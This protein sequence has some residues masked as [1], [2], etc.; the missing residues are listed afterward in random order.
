MSRSSRLESENKRLSMEV[1]EMKD[2]C[3]RSSTL[4]VKYKMQLEEEKNVKEDLMEGNA[5]LKKK[6]NDLS[7]RCFQQNEQIRVLES[8]LRRCS[9]ASSRASRV[10]VKVIGNISEIIKNVD[11]TETQPYIDL[12]RKYDELESEHR[13]AL[14]IIDELEFELGDVSAALKTRSCVCFV[15]FYYLL[16]SF[17]FS[18]FPL[19]LSFTFRVCVTLP[20]PILFITFYVYG[21]ARFYATD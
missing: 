2:A 9:G 12:Q 13:E 21:A 4:S 1:E 15:S 14:D 10:P 11:P 19:F 17:H 8:N 16:A 7:T 5:K 18:F 20:N 6:V 3:T